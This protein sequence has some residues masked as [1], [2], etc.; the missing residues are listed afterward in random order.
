MNQLQT[1]DTIL[2]T[3]AGFTHNLGTPLASGMWAQI[4]SHPAIQ[5]APL[6]RL[7]M[8]R[9]S[10]FYYEDAYETVMASES[11]F[12]E[13]D[14]IALSEAVESAYA[15]IDSVIIHYGIR[16]D[17]SVLL[18][19][20]WQLVN[21]FAGTDGKKG[22][23][24]TLNHDLLVEHL[25]RDDHMFSPVTLPGLDYT[26]H[27]RHKRAEEVLRVEDMVR[28]PSEEELNERRHVLRD[29]AYAFFYV[30]LHGS[31]NWVSSSGRQTLV[32]GKTKADQIAEEPL[33]AWYFLIFRSVLFRPNKRMLVIGYGFGDPHINK[34]IAEAVDR[35]HLAIH[36]VNPRPPE[37]LRAALG[38]NDGQII[39][40]DG[41]A[42]YYQFSF[43]DLF[44]RALDV[45]EP[46]RELYAN[47]FGKAPSGT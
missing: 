7:R 46:I 19:R 21:E 6:V 16:N 42:G 13:T 43:S 15:R 11:G 39:W 3:G 12:S 18:R 14:K 4:F 1:T 36:V 35:F 26:A 30:K 17:A 34:L 45:G 32:I 10:A 40:E 20:L 41:L 25:Y 2:L 9:E 8:L 37:E 33:L 44:P 24:F 5:R 27:L 22:F 29:K 31:Q 47:F 23:Y 38:S 28:I